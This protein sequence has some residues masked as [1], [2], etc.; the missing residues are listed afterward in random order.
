MRPYD[1][2]DDADADLEEIASYTLRR[3][4]EQ[5]VDVYMGLLEKRFEEIAAREVT[6]RQFS[7]RFPEVLVSRCEHHFIFYL[8]PEGQK[9]LI[10]AVYHENMDMIT[11]LRER[12]E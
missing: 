11:R 3:W 10:I 7:R 2:T 1:L 4:G 5:Q 12:L 6:P 8:H 9:P